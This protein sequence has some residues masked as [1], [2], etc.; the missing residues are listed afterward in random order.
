MKTTKKGDRE[1]YKDEYI[2]TIEVTI[3]LYTLVPLQRYMD[4]VFT[5]CLIEVLMKI[6]AKFGDSNPLLV[7]EH[8][9]SIPHN[10]ISVSYIFVK[11]KDTP[12]IHMV[13]KSSKRLLIP[14]VRQN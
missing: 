5:S 6:N 3:G 13:T 1:T 14:S 12:S 4:V 7:M 11:N 10:S 8:S 9:I 2:Q